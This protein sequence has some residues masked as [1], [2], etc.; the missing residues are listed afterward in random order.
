[1]WPLFRL[2]GARNVMEEYENASGRADSAET[3]SCAA[4]MAKRDQK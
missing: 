4:E 1:M 2:V 3:R